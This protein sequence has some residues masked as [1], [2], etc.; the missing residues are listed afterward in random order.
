M[1]VPL[2]QLYE[3]TDRARIY[4]VILD[5]QI[6][7]PSD[8][9]VASWNSTQIG[10]W[11][12][13]GQLIAV[14]NP[15]LIP[16]AS[17]TRAEIV[18]FH[19]AYIVKPDLSGMILFQRKSKN[20]FL[21]NILERTALRMVVKNAGDVIYLPENALLDQAVEQLMNGKMTLKQLMAL[22]A[23]GAHVDPRKTATREGRFIELVIVPRGVLFRCL[24]EPSLAGR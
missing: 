18:P 7:L 16:G 12:N 11:A 20:G 10:I 1:N 15:K 6:F 19:Q 9:S 22:E 23:E 17:T 5:G 4:F 3:S 8:T 21:I 2:S 24:K 13:K 14:Q